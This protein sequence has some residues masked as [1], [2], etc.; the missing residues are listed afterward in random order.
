MALSILVHQTLELV[1]DPCQ[2]WCFC[3]FSESF[4]CWV[5]VKRVQLTTWH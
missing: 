2:F 4:I 3:H 5:M 1:H